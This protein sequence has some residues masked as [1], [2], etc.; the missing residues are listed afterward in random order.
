MNV[1]FPVYGNANDDDDCFIKW[2]AAFGRELKSC[3]ILGATSFYKKN[4]ATETMDRGQEEEHFL[5]DDQLKLRIIWT[6]SC[7]ISS[8]ARHHFLKQIVSEHSQLQR[9][10]V[11]DCKNQ[12]ELCMDEEQIVEMRKSVDDSSLKDRT[13]LPDLSIKMLCLPVL[14]LPASGYTMRGATLV[15]IK[16]VHDDNDDGDDAGGDLLGG[17][18]DGDGEEKKKAFGEA[19]RELMKVKKSYVMT[20]NSF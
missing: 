19:V 12:G 11:S 14:E 13:P 17:W 4:L 5:T 9:V 1:Q 16:P 2:K 7:L 18:F 10:I 20:M 3:I 15:V 6:I 8:S